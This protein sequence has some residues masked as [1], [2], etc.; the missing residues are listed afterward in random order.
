MGF[1]AQSTMQMPC[2][3]NKLCF[4]TNYQDENIIQEVNC[5]GVPMISLDQIPKNHYYRIGI[6]GARDIRQ[7]KN[8]ELKNISVSSLSLSKTRLSLIE[9]FAFSGLEQTL[10]ALELSHGNIKEFPS[11]SLFS[12]QHLQWINL[13]GNEIEKVNRRDFK[14]LIS[15]KSLLLSD[16]SLSVIEDQTFKDII[17]LEYLELDDNLIT[18]IEG[19]PFP[20]SLTTLSLANCLLQELHANAI[21]NLKNIK[22]LQFRG[23]LIRH[24]SHLRLPTD[25]LEL[26]D[27]SHNLISS[28]DHNAFHNVFHSK[29]NINSDNPLTGKNINP[30]SN[31]TF[32]NNIVNSSDWLIHITDLHLD[33][34]FI[35]SLPSEAFKHISVERL[36]LSNNHITAE[37]IAHDAFVGPLQTKL[38]LLDLNYNLLEMYPKALLHLKQLKQLFIKSNKLKFIDEMSFANFNQLEAIDLSKNLLIRVPRAFKYAKSLVKLNL[39]DN[40]ITVITDDDFSNWST[41]LSFLNLAKNRIKIITANAFKDAKNLRELKLAGNNVYHLDEN[42][43]I[44]L[45]HLE[46]LELSYCFTA[47]NNEN[48]KEIISKVPPSLK[49]LQIDYN[50]LKYFDHNALNSFNEIIHIDLEGNQIEFI[51]NKLFSKASHV[52]SIILN[53]NKLRTIQSKTFSNLARLENI[54]LYHNQLETIEASAFCNLPKLNTLILSKNN[55][56]KIQPNSF[57]NLSS[58]SSLSILLNENKLNRFSFSIF[59]Q[60]SKQNVANA[61]YINVSHNEIEHLEAVFMASTNEISN[62]T[63]TYDDFQQKQTFNV[64]VLD[65]SHN[66]ISHLPNEFTETICLNLQALHMEYNTLTNIPVEALQQCNE[67]QILILDHNEISDHGTNQVN[68][69]CC[70][71][72]K[73]FSLRHNKISKLNNFESIFSN[74]NNLRVLDLADNFISMVPDG[75]FYGTKLHRLVLAR[76]RLDQSIIEK[77]TFHN[78]FSVKETLAYLDLSHNKIDKVPFHV[79]SCE[80]LIELNLANNIINELT[81]HSFAML[82]QLFELDLSN[83]PIEKIHSKTFFKTMPLLDSLKLI[84]NSLSAVPILA[85]PQLNSIDL[86]HNII[87]T[88]SSSSFTKTRKIT[89]L[90]LSNNQLSDVPKHIWRYMIDLR[91]LNLAYNPID[92]LDTSSFAELKKLSH[93]DIQGL[94]LHYVDTR[95]LHHHR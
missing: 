38:I 52:N 60:M 88:I 68:T 47:G 16:N 55:I 82:N 91:Y 45:L 81:E 54:A 26:L 29:Q 6:R 41:S 21:S 49:L 20:S 51:D 1:L 62:S 15:L 92:I 25:N 3:F 76:N 70:S 65:L 44:S 22:F 84:N 93:L 18:R 7:L 2:N 33:M 90:N 8:N 67:L 77:Q 40:Y 19:N 56:S 34:N 74:M 36:S 80:N 53:R 58:S 32:G 64:R 89:I 23:N 27:L 5:I 9:S 4:C 73:V 13:R 10:T 24:L 48:L 42:V 35:Q 50:N 83:N 57:Y 31:N 61:M 75:V 43:I 79:T 69:T 12:L 85:L 66:K 63:L 87:T 59:K 30:K 72:L 86:S 11:E 17:N 78:C 94:A 14:K 37:L 39:Q 46:S 28:L 71:N 95:L